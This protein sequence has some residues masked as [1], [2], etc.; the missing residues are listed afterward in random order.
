MVEYPI[1]NAIIAVFHRYLPVTSIEIYGRLISSLFSL[2][3]ISILYYFALHEKNRAAAIATASI[4][5]VFPY[6]VFSLGRLTKLL[7]S[8]L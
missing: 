1:Y 3:T 4:F 7:Q 6:F 8:H 2:I 5:A